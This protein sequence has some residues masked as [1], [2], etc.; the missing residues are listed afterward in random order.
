M[1]QD[2]LFVEL[3]LKDTKE[4]RSQHLWVELSVG[5]NAALGSIVREGESHM[6]L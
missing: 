1:S 3:L 6:N 2:G 4:S 5:R